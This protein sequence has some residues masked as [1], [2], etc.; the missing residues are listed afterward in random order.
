MK[1]FYSDII[2]ASLIILLT[3]NILS[4]VIP[5]FSIIQNSKAQNN[6][7]HVDSSSSTLADEYLDVHKRCEHGGG[8]FKRLSGHHNVCI[9]IDHYHDH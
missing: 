7:R 5:T 4:I 8:I 1:I 9:F 2:I 3:F 6:N